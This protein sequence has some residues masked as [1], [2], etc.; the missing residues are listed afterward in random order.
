MRSFDT[1]TTG[2]ALQIRHELQALRRC[3]LVFYLLS[4]PISGAIRHSL[5][6]TS[7]K[8][9]NVPR[10]LLGGEIM[11]L[12]SV[13]F[14]DWI[15]IFSIQHHYLSFISLQVFSCSLFQTFFRSCLWSALI[16]AKRDLVPSAITAS[17]PLLSLSVRV[18]KT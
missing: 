12:S 7:F 17:V 13:I 8:C 6:R 3:I 11:Y 2:F 14:Q 1:S 16:V 5:G 4:E 10:A 15:T 9:V 18:E